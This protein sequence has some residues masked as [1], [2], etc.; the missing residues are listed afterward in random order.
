MHVVNAVDAAGAADEA[1][2]ELDADV[3]YVDADFDFA[4]ELGPA[5]FCIVTQTI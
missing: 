2:L 5:L 1:A 4:V 3:D